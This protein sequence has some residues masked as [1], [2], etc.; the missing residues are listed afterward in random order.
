MSQA[1]V[2]EE[3]QDLLL[4]LGNPEA[5]SLAYGDAVQQLAHRCPVF[6]EVQMVPTAWSVGQWTDAS[7]TFTDDTTDAQSAATNDVLLCSTIDNDGHLIG[8]YGMFERVVYTISTTDG[9]LGVYEF[10]YWNS[11][12]WTAL[13]L[14][15][16]PNFGSS[17]EQTLSFVAPEDWRQGRPTGV[18]SPDADGFDAD[19]F[20]IR[21][22]A[23]TAP[24]GFTSQ[25]QLE[26]MS[27]AMFLTVPPKGNNRGDMNQAA[28]LAR[29]P[30]AAPY[31]QIPSATQLSLQT[32]IYPLPDSLVH[33]LTALYYPN[34]LEPAPVAEG[35]DLLSPTW[36][37]TTG[38]PTRF[39]QDLEPFPRLRLSPIPTAIGARGVPV[40]TGTSGATVGTNNLVLFT[41][42]VPLEEDM[43]PWFE[44]LVSY[45]VAAREARRMGET[46]DLA[47]ANALEQLVDG[48]VGMLTSFWADDG[49]ELAVP[50]VSPL[51]R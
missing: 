37:A 29:V 15:S 46:Q 21:V 39:T 18:T 16:T 42:Q 20:W 11:V 8:A 34:E 26:S 51:R 31:F 33:L 12:D 43:P 5:V 41:L 27:Q 3:V 35:L 2:L 45:A 22:R 7:Q 25:D 13:S 19:L 1:S 24:G 14:I 36:R 40:F 17:G 38:T 30:L 9:G 10:T 44:G 32:A 48:L 49:L 28:G 50:Y 4:N 23:T 47:L 6:S